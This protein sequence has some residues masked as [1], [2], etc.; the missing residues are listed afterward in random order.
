M[1]TGGGWG[2]G[3]GAVGDSN[4]TQPARPILSCCS[5]TH[6]SITHADTAS[7]SAPKPMPWTPKLQSP[8]LTQRIP[9]PPFGD[10]KGRHVVSYEEYVKTGGY[11]GLRKALTMTPEQVTDAVKT[12]ELRGRGGAGFPTGLKWTFLP[13][14]TT[15]ATAARATSPSTP[16]RANPEHSKT[17]CSWTSIRTW[18]SKASRSAATPAESRQR[19]S[20]SAAN[21]TIRRWS[22]RTP[23]ARRTATACSASKVSCTAQRAATRSKTVRTARAGL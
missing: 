18:S 3:I 19:T 8:V 2:A 4:H 23:S 22:W 7:H 13:N 20:T 9:C 10:P 14:P 1:G 6:R 12:S 5:P 15:T 16:T 17:A 21:T 11:E